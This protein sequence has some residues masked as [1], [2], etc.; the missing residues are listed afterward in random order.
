MLVSAVTLAAVV[1]CENWGNTVDLR[2]AAS[3]DTAVFALGDACT[4]TAVLLGDPTVLVG[5]R[6]TTDDVTLRNTFVDC[7]A[8]DTSF[9]EEVVAVDVGSTLT[10]AGPNVGGNRT[11][12][13]QTRVVALGNACSAINVL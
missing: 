8:L 12:P 9:R 6:D 3:D 11:A 4:V 2:D 10:G 7:V 1:A 5:L 13:D